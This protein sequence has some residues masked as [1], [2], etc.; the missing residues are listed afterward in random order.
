MGVAATRDTRKPPPM[1]SLIRT[2]QRVLPQGPDQRQHRCGCAHSLLPKN[3]KEGNEGNGG[4]EGK[5]K[6]REGQF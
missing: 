5:S 4:N 6:F 2:L 1:L 3:G